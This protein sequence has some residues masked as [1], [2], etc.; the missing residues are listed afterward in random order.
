M[1]KIKFFMLT[2]C[3]L[4]AGVISFAFVGTSSVYA[5]STTT[6][7]VEELSKAPNL[8]GVTEINNLIVFV[9]LKGETE[10]MSYAEEVVQ[11]VEKLTNT[12]KDSLYNY[13]KALSNGNLRL[14]SKI[15]TVTKNGVTDYFIHEAKSISKDD[16]YPTNR[17]ELEA[18]LI[19]DALDELDLYP[20]NVPSASELDTN[21]DDIIDSITML[22]I[23]QGDNKV[24]IGNDNDM[25]LWPHHWGTNGKCYPSIKDKTVSG[26]ML[27]TSDMIDYG[28]VDDTCSCYAHEMGHQLGFPDLYESKSGGAFNVGEW[29]I[30]ALNSLQYM[31]S[32]SRWVAGWIKNSQFVKMSINGTY[33]LKPVNYDEENVLND[34]TLSNP[35]ICYYVEDPN[36]AGQY[37]CFEYRKRDGLFDQYLPNEGLLIYRIDTNLVKNQYYL[38]SNN[39]S[40]TSASMHIMRPVNQTVPAVYGNETKTFGIATNLYSTVT[41]G[42]YITYQVYDSSKDMEKQT[43]SYVNSGIVVTDIV[44]NSNGT[45]SF[46][47]D[48]PSLQVNPEVD[49]SAFNDQVLY[50]RLLKAIGK[51]KTETAYYNDFKDLTSLDLSGQGITDLTGLDT[52]NLSSLTYLNLS[53]NPLVNG[54]DLLSQLDSLETLVMMDCGLVEIGFIPSNVKY[55]NFASNSIQDFSPLSNLILL[56]KA[57]MVFNQFDASINENASIRLLVEKGDSRYIIGIQN[58]GATTYLGQKYVL[59]SGSNFDSNVTFM[60]SKDNSNITTTLTSGLVL[61]DTGSYKAVL[62]VPKNSVFNQEAEYTKTI[63]FRIINVSLKTDYVE[64]MQGKT[65][66]PD[67]S[68]S[69]V[70]YT[71]SL[72]LDIS[73]YYGDDRTAVDKVDTAVAGMYY[74]IFTITSENSTD[75]M[76]LVKKVKVFGNEYITFGYDEHGNENDMPDVNLYKALL[77]IVGKSNSDLGANDENKLFVQDFYFYDVNNTGVD[78]I[79]QIDLSSKQISSLKGIELLNLSKVTKIIVDNNSITDISPLFNF[80]HLKELF[81]FNNNISSIDGIA[82]M[83]GLTKLDLSYNIITDVSPLKSLT[84][85]YTLIEN[86]NAQNLTCVNVMFNMLDMNKTNNS[87]IISN[88]QTLAMISPYK[89]FIVLVQGLSDGDIYTWYKGTPDS[90]KSNFSYYQTQA[91]TYVDSSGKEAKYYAVLVGSNEV[92]WE[93]GQQAIK[94]GTFTVG[95]KI[96]KNLFKADG[97]QSRKKVYYAVELT[98]KDLTPKAGVTESLLLSSEDP[99]AVLSTEVI[100]LP[101]VGD[102]K[103]GSVS[104]LTLSDDRKNVEVVYLE[105]S[106]GRK[107]QNGTAGRYQ[108]HYIITTYN[109]KTGNISDSTS[110]YRIIDVISNSQVR[111]NPGAVNYADQN[112]KDKAIGVIDEN[113]WKALLKL[114]GVTEKENIDGNYFKYI[115]KYDTYNLTSLDLQNLGIEYINGINEFAL[116][117]VTAIRLNNNKIKSVVP[118]EKIPSDTFK[119]LIVIDLS[120]NQITDAS[121]LVDFKVVQDASVIAQGKNSTVY[122]NLMLNKLD[123]SN[124]T[125]RF[126]L[127]ENSY[128]HTGNYFM[129]AI[130]VGLQGLEASQD[131][132]TYNTERSKAGFYY[133]DENIK[134]AKLV[135]DAIHKEVDEGSVDYVY[136]QYYYFEEAGEYEVKFSAN[137]NVS[138]VSVSRINFTGKIRHGKVY[139]SSNEVDVDYSATDN[140]DERDIVINDTSLVFEGIPQE[141]YQIQSQIPNF[142]LSRKARFEQTTNVYLKDDIAQ[143][144]IFRKIVNVKDREAPVITFTGNNFIIIHK[145][146][147]TGLNSRYGV[148]VEVTAT[149]NYDSNV[150]INIEVLN[151]KGESVD[152]VDVDKPDVYT[153]IFK[154][155]DSSQNEAE[156]VQRVIKVIYRPYTVVMLDKPEARFMTGEVE[157]KVQLII[158]EGEDVNPNPV[159]YWF[160]DGEY[161][162]SSLPVESDNEYVVK[163]VFKY[164]AKTA[165]EHIVTLRINNMTGDPSEENQT[166]Y[167]RTFFVLLD[168]NVL[169]I[170]IGVGVGIVV[171]TIATIVTIFAFK[172]H[173]R[174]KY[175]EYENKTYR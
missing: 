168:N 56:E 101:D 36:Y 145:G 29:D 75:V 76:V 165:G 153:V 67:S 155:R 174:N 128:N 160:V 108:I 169:N 63:N 86:G 42:N 136:N 48:A 90:Q 110:V 143:S 41:S 163:S 40:T 10:Q 99:N 17:N 126:L 72:G 105:N 80:V 135:S 122:I 152:R 142:T 115:N 82:V 6:D 125:N 81:A 102:I 98:L 38:P 30:M 15:A 4:C 140:Q 113:L 127:D 92:K 88:N 2:L 45:M 167:E 148:D 162:D 131:R 103:F 107:F 59:Y 44:F 64:V 130:L 91:N 9:V 32:Y 137:F 175:Q 7:I 61:L 77:T 154:A 47:I 78:P 109:A 93:N 106:S 13:Y 157:F 114:T 79:T 166:P 28:R 119:N 62:T 68:S 5:V 21:N 33:T 54:L 100:M 66:S 132:V 3:C 11:K 104:G 58:V 19:K 39:Y 123:L 27:F 121:P 25:L 133:Y 139:L 134:Y 158:A 57:L 150:Q 14:K 89:I 8:Q 20:N 129:N 53:K 31:N 161:I 50:E 151:S 138:S 118:I 52:V 1:N 69:L 37:I 26:Y 173:R 172:K 22:V 51:S 95:A 83:T 124:N 116:P 65:Y 71:G 43:I 164:E 170:V 18:N 171:V 73:V 146:E 112:E 159:F 24:D 84:E 35:V 111:Y 34:S 85:P 55:V 74:V 141:E 16:L 87:W 23:N 96:N 12:N 49:A 97:L 70:G 147:P 60:M 94:S 117:K 46:S 144:G 149:D 156:S 120:C